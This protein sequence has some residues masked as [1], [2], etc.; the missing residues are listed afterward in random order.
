[1]NIWVDSTALARWLLSLIVWINKDICRCGKSDGSTQA[2]ASRS[3]R[4]ITLFDTL[5]LICLNVVSTEEVLH[6]GRFVA[7]PLI[8][9][10][11][12][13]FPVWVIFTD[14]VHSLNKFDFQ[15]PFFFYFTNLFINLWLYLFSLLFPP[16]LLYA[17]VSC[18]RSY[19]CWLFREFFR[20]VILVANCWHVLDFYLWLRCPIII[21]FIPNETE[22]VP[23]RAV[24]T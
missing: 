8:E 9:I 21:C 1:M 18:S 12:V 15:L 23:G 20:F 4:S 11:V 14:R 2:T 22:F 10:I 19:C 3:E 5:L 13:L 6:V 17:T 24:V 16:G 7:S